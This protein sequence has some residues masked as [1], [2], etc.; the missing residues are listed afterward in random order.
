MKSNKV[1]FIKYGQKQDKTL[2]IQTLNFKTHNTGTP[3][4]DIADF[5]LVDII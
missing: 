5:G 3:R 4:H 1:F 2:A